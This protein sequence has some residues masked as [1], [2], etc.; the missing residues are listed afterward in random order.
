MKWNQSYS[1]GIEEI[2][3]QHQKL[4]GML[5]QLI[6]A[7][8]EKDSKSVVKDILD[9]LVEYTVYHFNTEERYFEQFDYENKVEHKAEHKTFTDKVALFVNDYKEDRILLT[10]DILMFLSNWIQNHIKGSDKLY[11]E[12]FQANG[13]SKPINKQLA[14]QTKPYRKANSQELNTAKEINFSVIMIVIAI[15][16]MIVG[17]VVNF[18]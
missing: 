16:V 7:T 5:A 8:D 6:K 3:R 18:V 13:L 1:V 12:C 15:F 2:D 10:A 9:N 4:I 14:R 11:T 17:F